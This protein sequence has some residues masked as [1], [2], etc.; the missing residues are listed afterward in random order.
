[1][2]RAPSIHPRDGLTA[3]GVSAALTAVAGGAAWRVWR[4]H[5]RS[6]RLAEPID[7]SPGAGSTV[8]ASLAVRRHGPSGRPIVLLHG[9]GGS[10]S[11]WGAGYDCLG[12]QHRVIAVDLLG[13]G[14]SPHPRTGYTLANHADAV[15]STLSDVGVGEPAVV[16][17]HSFGALVALRL[18]LSHPQLV[19]GVLAMCPPLFRCAADARERTAAAMTSLE[20]LLYLPTWRS[21]LI[22][23]NVCMKRPRLAESWARR[24]RDE[25]PPALVVDAMRHT[26]DSYSQSI[27]QLLDATAAP[28]WLARLPVPV[29][30]LVGGG[31]AMLDMS[32]LEELAADHRHVRLRR[33][34]HA[35]HL[36]PLTHVEEC[37]L[38]VRSLTARVEASR[39]V[40]EIRERDPADVAL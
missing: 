15:A 18:A 26:W 22:C 8:A 19:A 1:M 30:L 38:A 32:L 34:E 4:R 33:V 39:T 13:C 25:L 23:R 27:A 10:Q 24:V 35:A 2:W 7:W 37:V 36:L 11:I 3:L 16:V 29:D 40:P 31:D 17:G 14:M 5:G 28:E 20:R 12:D 6:L 21:G 9:L